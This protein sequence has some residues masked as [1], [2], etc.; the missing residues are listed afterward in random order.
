MQARAGQRKRVWEPPKTAREHLRS[1]GKAI[2]TG[3]APFVFAQTPRKTWS[4]TR[5]EEYVETL[6]AEIADGADPA[7]LAPH[8]DS[9]NAILK[10]RNTPKDKDATASGGN[11]SARAG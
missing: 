9:A 5:L 11:E 6:H 1:L 8:I 3:K 4:T 2:P 7:L 10:A